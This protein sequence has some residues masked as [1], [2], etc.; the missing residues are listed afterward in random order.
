VP[1]L[2]VFR[3]PP[4]AHHQLAAADATR[5]LA[6]GVDGFQIDHAYRDLFPAAG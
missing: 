1:A 3:Y 5:L 2:N 6:A 4:H